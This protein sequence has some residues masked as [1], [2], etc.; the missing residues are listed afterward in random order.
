M[1][2]DELE[3]GELSGDGGAASEKDAGGEHEAPSGEAEA[4]A[5]EGAALG[6][7]GAAM[8][9]HDDHDDGPEAAS[10]SRSAL[11]AEKAGLYGKKFAARALDTAL[12]APMHAIDQLSIADVHA[13]D[14]ANFMASG[15]KTRAQRQK[16]KV[17]DPINY[18]PKGAH[19]TKLPLG[20]RLLRETGRTGLRDTASHGRNPA[21]FGQDPSHPLAQKRWGWGQKHLGKNPVAALRMASLPEEA[22]PDSADN[23]RIRAIKD[24]LRRGKK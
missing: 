12:F 11:K 4:G 16:Q 13:V 14:A 23:R 3:R 10:P 2:W 5:G 18:K 21:I 6:P 19:V 9:E 8:P 22:A 7:A 24:Q 17:D 1:F 20:E 15:G